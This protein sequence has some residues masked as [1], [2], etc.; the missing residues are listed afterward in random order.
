ML[1]FL[2]TAADMSLPIGAASKLFTPLT[3]GNGKITLKHR[4]VLAPL[5]RNRGIPL[6]ESTPEDPNRIWYPDELVA[7]YY[8]QRTT[9]GGLLISE[10]IPPCVRVR[11]I[12]EKLHSSHMG[13]YGVAVRRYAWCTRSLHSH[14]G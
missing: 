8:R 4:V 10:G 11:Q 14:A 9:D 3:I 6:K 5:T 7:E 13:L 2:E 1:V 12:K